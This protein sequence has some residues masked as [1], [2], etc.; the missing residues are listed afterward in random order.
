MHTLQWPIHS[1]TCNKSGPLYRRSL[2]PCLY[3]C[4]CYN[5]TT[6]FRPLFPVPTFCG[7]R[8]A[9]MHT[10]TPHNFSALSQFLPLLEQVCQ[11]TADVF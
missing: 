3:Q 11:P 10:G 5:C 8:Q 7:D 1:R 2:E 4:P 6:Q 9:L